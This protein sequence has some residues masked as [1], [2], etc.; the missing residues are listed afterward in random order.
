MVEAGIRKFAPTTGILFPIFIFAGFAI[1]GSPRDV[2]EP[3]AE[4]VQFHIDNESQ[5]IIATFLAALAILAL[6]VFG[7][8]L[9]TRLRDAGSRVLA[10]AVGLTSLDSKMLPTP[11]VGL[12]LLAAVLLIIPVLPVALA[13]IALVSL[14][15]I[16]TGIVLLRCPASTAA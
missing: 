3:A 8:E 2:D 16:A 10:A 15:S 6:L 13:G 14:W 7:A 1:E 9:R 12:G 5:T 4:I 11:I